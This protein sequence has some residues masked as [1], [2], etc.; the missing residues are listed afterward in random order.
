[1]STT[2]R[3]D[4]DEQGKSIDQKL[5][6]SMIGLLLYLTA[7]RPDILFSVCLCARFQASPKESHLHTVKRIFKYLAYTPSLGLWYPRN[8]SFDLQTYSDANFGGYKVDRKSTSGTF[9][10]N[11]LISWF[12]KK[13]NWVALSSTETEYIATVSCCAQVM[14]MKQQLLD[15]GFSF[16]KVPIMC[17]NTSAICLGK[18]LVHHSRTKHIDIRY[19]FI[20]DHIEKCDIELVF[21]P[22]Q[23]QITDIFTKPLDE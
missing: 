22:T 6:R 2:T 11:M 5:Y 17:D 19:H 13:Q 18:N 10:G 15:Y 7:S 16:D 3:L 8:S 1:M 14:W 12:S 21:V 23:D 20:K 9:L 4:K